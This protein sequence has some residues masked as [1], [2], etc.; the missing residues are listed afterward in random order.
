V[1]KSILTCA[2]DVIQLNGSMH[3]LGVWLCCGGSAAGQHKYDNA[4]AACRC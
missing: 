4:Y 1:V 3:W 2:G